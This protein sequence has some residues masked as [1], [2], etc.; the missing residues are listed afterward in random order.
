MGRHCRVRLEAE[1]RCNFQCGQR[2]SIQGKY[3]HSILHA[4]PCNPFTSTCTMAFEATA[5]Q[6]CPIDWF[7]WL[8]SD[9]LCPCSWVLQLE[10]D[11]H[12]LRRLVYLPAVVP[13]FARCDNDGNSR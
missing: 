2:C 10:E 6:T 3:P 1:R 11:G 5:Q 9:E 8:R 4:A 7:S 12:P 13:K